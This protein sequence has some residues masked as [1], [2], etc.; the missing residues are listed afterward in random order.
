MS[1]IR[2]I[3]NSK[4]RMLHYIECTL[5][6]GVI[7]PLIQLKHY[8]LYL[9]GGGMAADSLVSFFYDNDI[10][11]RGII[12]KDETK[13]NKRVFLDVPYIYTSE[14]NAERIEDI[15]NVFVIITTPKFYG[16]EQIEIINF[17]F[18][19][20]VDKMF[21]I[22]Q[23]EWQE[24]LGLQVYYAEYYRTHVDDLE[25]VYGMLADE[26]SRRIMAEY[27]RTAMEYDVYSLEQEHGKNK[28]FYEGVL[29]SERREIYRH[30]QEEIWVNCGAS[31]GDSIFLFF[32]NGLTAKRIYAFEGDKGAY[33]KLSS[34]MAYLPQN[35]LGKVE[36]I[37]EYI[38]ADT[39]FEQYISEPVTL[40]NADIE[41]NELSMVRAMADI[42]VRDRPVLAICVYHQVKDIVEIPQYI[43]NIVDNYRYVLR[44]YSGSTKND[45]TRTWELVLYAVPDERF[46]LS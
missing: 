22:P 4:K 40:I 19:A 38:S 41:A 10:K 1:R 24:L 6:G 26:K 35:L 25:T 46:V 7:C 31:I 23:N 37:N 9:Y 32:A 3:V 27:I 36:V 33:Q 20:G 43:N 13:K 28:Y 16:I 8:D 21:A 11:V 17:L 18:H 2:E 30:L 14:F 39:T 5:L 15:S 42:I 34:S 44:K 12:D 45:V 29:T